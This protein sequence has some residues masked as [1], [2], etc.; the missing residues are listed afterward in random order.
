MG[1]ELR[2]ILEEFYIWKS[3]EGNKP[4]TIRWYKVHA[5]QFLDTMHLSE[6]NE[7]TPHNISLFL[8]KKQE[9]CTSGGLFMYYRV[10][11]L[12]SKWMTLHGYLSSDIV[13]RIPKPRHK[14]T[15]KQGFSLAD[16]RSILAAAKRT[17]YPEFNVAMVVTLY[18]TG[19]RAG[20][21][22]SLRMSDINWQ[23]REIKVQGKMG[24]RTCPIGKTALRKIK[25]YLTRA[26]KAPSEVQ[27]V[28][29]TRNGKPLD[30]A[31]ITQKIKRLTK[32]AGIEKEEYLGP[33]AFRHGFA[34]QFLRNG[35]SVVHLKEILG[36]QDI[37]MTEKYLS[38]AGRDLSEQHKK[39][40]PV[41]MMAE[42]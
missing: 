5:E 34:V 13:P 25:R 40:S 15:K 24:Q 22:C 1:S 37:S 16:V 10:L 39:F 32:M 29:V 8:H 7:W 9:T 11:R 14:Y 42:L 23:Q 35:G 27:E 20:E 2:N 21:L 26:R 6:L 4:S 18:D 17:Y 3:N 36:H 30:T 12:I 38:L 19:I 41:E 33:H 31:Y 28:F